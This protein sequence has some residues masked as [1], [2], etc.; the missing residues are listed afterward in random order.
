MLQVKPPFA[1]WLELLSRKRARIQL[2]ASSQEVNVETQA[3]ERTHALCISSPCTV[4]VTGVQQ[5]D[6][7]QLVGLYTCRLQGGGG[8]IGIWRGRL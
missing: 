3:G 6:G 8:G 4:N 5:K 2:V 1:W 7:K